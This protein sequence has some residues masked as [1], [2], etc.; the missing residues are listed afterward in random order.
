MADLHIHRPH[1]LGLARARRIAWA[2]AE[3]AESEHAMVCEYAQGRGA[4]EVRFSRSGVQ[5]TLHVRKDSFTLD[6][7][8]G[9]LVGA[10][11]GAIEAEITRTL[12]ALLTDPSAG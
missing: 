3:Q 7:Q 6:A 8:L 10:F 4:D 12:D 9:L 1:T 2:W 5:G 11:K